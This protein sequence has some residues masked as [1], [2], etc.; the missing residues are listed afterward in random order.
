MRPAALRTGLAWMLFA[1]ATLC[2]AA[3][4]PVST[5]MT[6]YTDPVGG[7]SLQY[8]AVWTVSKT[9]TSYF[10]S[11]IAPN[12]E[13]VEA[14][15]SFSPNGNYYEHTTLT[16]LRF[17]YRRV[18]GATQSACESTLT[19]NRPVGTLGHLTLHG[20]RFAHVS[21]GEAGM[22]KSESQEAYAAWRGGTCY[23]FEEQLDQIAPGTDDQKTR[24]LTRAEIRAL[25]RHLH[26][27][28]AFCHDRRD[29]VR[30]SPSVARACLQVGSHDQYRVRTVPSQQH[31]RRTLA[32]ERGGFCDPAGARSV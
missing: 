6:S 2:H 7:V 21:T 31:A 18:E 8:P 30:A 15:F 17:L 28:S 4:Q 26:R 14:V 25:R 5:P 20:A 23:L 12:G 1:L 9:A 24:S 11:A 19:T 32:G 16:G 10:P 3:V 13:P 27:H 22:M 29:R